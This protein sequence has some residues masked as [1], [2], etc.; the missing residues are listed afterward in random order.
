MDQVRS[1]VAAPTSEPERAAGSK[2]PV[3]GRIELSTE[4]A[5]WLKHLPARH[6]ATVAFYLDLLAQQGPGLRWPHVRTL[7]GNLRKLRFHLDGRAV[8]ITY[9]IGSDHRIVLLTVFMK[10]HGRERLEIDRARAALRRWQLRNGR[11]RDRSEAAG[12]KGCEVDASR[13]ETGEGRDG[14]RSRTESTAL[15]SKWP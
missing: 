5:E 15:P 12:L 2:K 6:L 7:E 1:R 10:A 11:S 3:G 9:W 13:G 14:G 8:R 4:L